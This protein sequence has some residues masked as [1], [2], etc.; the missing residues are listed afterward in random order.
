MELS[1]ENLLYGG[2][3][4][5]K[6]KGTIT[7]SRKS[8]FPGE[9]SLKAIPGFEERYIVHYNA[10]GGYAYGAIRKED[11]GKTVIAITRVETGYRYK[12]LRVRDDMVGGSW[13]CS[14]DDGFK[15]V[16]MEQLISDIRADSNKKTSG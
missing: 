12:L 10:N 4:L 2:R 11:Q 7:D 9:D 3:D 14:Q 15:P 5:D 13:S 8:F 6:P 16:D 1:F